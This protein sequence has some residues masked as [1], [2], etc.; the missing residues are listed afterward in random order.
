M[1]CLFIKSMFYTKTKL[2]R[3]VGKRGICESIC[4]IC[5]S[6]TGLFFVG[7]VLIVFNWFTC[8]TKSSVSVLGPGRNKFV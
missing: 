7:F 8:L 2:C 1:Y 6:L 4:L 5:V 3:V